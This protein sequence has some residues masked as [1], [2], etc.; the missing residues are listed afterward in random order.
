MRNCHKWV[1]RV[2]KHNPAK[3]SERPDK[4]IEADDML[5]EF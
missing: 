1:G 4:V 3:V 2:G 5:L